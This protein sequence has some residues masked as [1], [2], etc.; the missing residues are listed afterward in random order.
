[1]RPEKIRSGLDFRNLLLV[2][3]ARFSAGAHPRLPA[4]ELPGRLKPEQL[5]GLA[6]ASHD[7]ATRAPT[8]L[9]KRC[10]GAAALAPLALPWL[11]DHMLPIQQCTSTA[12]E[13]A[14]P[15]VGWAAEF[16][17]LHHVLQAAAA[18]PGARGRR[19]LQQAKFA[20]VH[21]EVAVASPGL[22]PSPGR[23]PSPLT[24]VGALQPSGFGS[25]SCLRQGGA[26]RRADP[27][28]HPRAWQHVHPQPMAV[29]DGLQ[30]GRSRRAR[31]T[32]K[33][34]SQPTALAGLNAPPAPRSTTPLASVQP[35]RGE[36]T[37]TIAGATGPQQAAASLVGKS[38]SSRG[39]PVE[40]ARGGGARTHTVGT[41]PSVKGR[42]DRG[43]H[44][45]GA[46]GARPSKL[47]SAWPWG[48]ASRGDRRGIKRCVQGP[49]EPSFPWGGQGL[50]SAQHVLPDG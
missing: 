8:R 12:E 1:M 50:G 37:S 16:I 40:Q 9:S 45:G 19:P 31:P 18:K 29:A 32:P 10:A 3:I 34:S 36:G 24:A 14:G 44:R 28:R 41:G 46:P 33:R 11:R 15:T 47:P 38:S 7:W 23:A 6:G 26:G 2:G 27:P 39:S 30:I 4:A 21:L 25:L 20:T 13:A 22:R 42:R 43:T 49:V 35:T 5:A 48:S 17:P